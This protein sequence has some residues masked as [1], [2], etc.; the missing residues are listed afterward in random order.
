MPKRSLNQ[1]RFPLLDQ[2]LIPLRLPTISEAERDRSTEAAGETPQAPAAEVMATMPT[3]CPPGVVLQHPHEADPLYHQDWTQVQ[4]SGWDDEKW[5]REQQLRE[6]RSV[7]IREK[8]TAGFSVFYK[9]SGNS[10]WPLVQSGDACMFHPIQAVTAEGPFPIQKGRSE[11]GVGDIV[12]CQVQPS[13]RYY[14]HIVRAVKGAHEYKIGNIKGHINGWCY[15]EHIFGILVDVQVVSDTDGQYY[16]RPHPKALFEEVSQLVERDRWNDT[17]RNL[18]MPLGMPGWNSYASSSSEQR[19][20][21]LPVRTT[22][23]GW[24]SWD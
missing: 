12:F 5:E 22:P 20:G 15:R 3:R 2:R 16:S 9:S 11:I 1:R 13:L 19:S 4:G 7:L 17:A 23:Q 24:N 6:R 21:S 18:C 14:A 10:M 8:L